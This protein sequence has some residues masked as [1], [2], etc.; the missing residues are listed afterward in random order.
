MRV[1]IIYFLKRE[2]NLQSFC[3]HLDSKSKYISVYFFSTELDTGDDPDFIPGGEDPES[4]VEM[5][6]EVCVSFY[7][8]SKF[9][10]L[11]QWESV[12]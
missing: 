8:L 10:W 1:R 2:S 5:K 9:V 7:I 12:W 11:C 4:E 6:K 3:L